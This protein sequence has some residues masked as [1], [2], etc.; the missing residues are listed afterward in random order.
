MLKPGNSYEAV[1]NS[2]RWDIPQYYNIGVDICDKWARQPDR[3][4]LIYRN[5]SG[6]VEKY[7]F[8]DLK[9]LLK[10]IAYYW[11]TCGL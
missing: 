9:P 5:E 6:R 1:Y 2:F 10:T 8:A 4:A 3:L 7:T 11:I